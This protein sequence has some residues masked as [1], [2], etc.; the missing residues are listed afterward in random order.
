[1][2]MRLL[3]LALMLLSLVMSAALPAAFGAWRLLLIGAGIG[4]FTGPNQTLLMS[5][6]AREMMAAASAL[7]NLSARIGSVVGPMAIGLLWAMTPGVASQMV[8]GIAALMALSVFTLICV[9]LERRSEP[10]SG[11]RMASER[12]ADLAIHK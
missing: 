4:L 6:G 5:T 9:V 8:L 12:A 1:M 10:S 7:S 3:L 11:T 2:Q